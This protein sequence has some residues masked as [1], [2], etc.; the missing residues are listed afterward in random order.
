MNEILNNVAKKQLAA[1]LNIPV[2]SA[3]EILDGVIVPDI[4]QVKTLSECY[5]YTM[6]YLIREIVAMNG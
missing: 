5:G 1:I 3:I 6:D 4:E 2:E